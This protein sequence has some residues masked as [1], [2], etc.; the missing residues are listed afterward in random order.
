MKYDRSLR[1]EALKNKVA[2]D[3][4]PKFDCTNILGNVDFSVC[5]KDDTPTLF[6]NEFLLWGEAKRGAVADFR[7]SFAQLILTIGKEKTFDRYL[8]PQW[9]CEFDAAQIAF[10]PYSEILAIF[11]ENDFNWNVTP[12]DHDTRE[13]KALYDRVKGILDNGSYVFSFDEDERLL[14]EFIKAN[15]KVGKR[16]VSKRRITK[17]NFISIYNRW[18]DEVKPSI[19]VNW[20]ALKKKGILDSDFY[21]ADIMSKDNV[22]IMQKL[23]VLLVQTK[24]VLDQHIDE[25]GLFSSKSAGFNDDGVAHARF[26]LKYER[27]PKKEYQDEIIERRELLVPQDVRR[28]KG[29]YFTPDQWVELSQQYIERALGENWQEEYYIWDPAAGTGNLLVGL[30]DKYR[31]FASTLDKADV[32]VMRERIRNG[33]NLLDSHVFQFDFL[34]DPFTKLPDTLQ[35]IIGNPEKRAR[36]LLYLNPPYLDTTKDSDRDEATEV[37]NR[38]SDRL[39]LASRELFAQFMVRIYAEIPGVKMGVF[40]KLKAFNGSDFS[41]FRSYFKA[42]LLSMFIVPA[43][44][45]DNV[46]GDFPIGFQIWDTS[47]PEPFGSYKAD[48]YSEDADYIGEKGIYLPVSKSHYISNWVG[49]FKDD[50][51]SHLRLG[52]IEGST[53]NDF[54]HVRYISVS[55]GPSVANSQPRGNWITPE[56]LIHN[57]VSFA[58]RYA[59][60]PTWINDR[61]Q[62]LIPAHTWEDDAAFQLDCLVMLLFHGQNRITA[63][64]NGTNHWIPFSEAEVEARDIFRSHFMSD[65]IA[66]FRAGGHRPGN[67]GFFSGNSVPVDFSPEA[68]RVM[69]SGRE[70]WRYYQARIDA[71]ADSSLYDIREYFQGRNERGTMNGTSSDEGYTERMLCLRTAMRELKERIVP[72]VYE[73]GFLIK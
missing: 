9:L 3:F 55:N 13:F 73:H 58:V 46:K 68:G 28:K 60:A 11:Y 56:N 53:R 38:Y 33:A 47:V 15:L 25:S 64:D 63:R 72:K 4:F 29:S 41:V 57:A 30:N 54:Q 23:H 21:L 69:A 18:L 51:I 71:K 5:V 50:E 22:P 24:Y 36:L 35:E 37:A 42:T 40:S 45:F 7:T 67:S 1:E 49:S 34:N 52:W 26:W 17:N 62:F 10:I 39:S 44:T 14:R 59:I 66:S 12:S 19:A 70:L 32:D 61:D 2:E 48:V 27:P 43:Y 16:D 20:E 8:P 65:F 6:D 31:V